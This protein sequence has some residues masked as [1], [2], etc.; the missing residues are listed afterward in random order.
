M[1]SIHSRLFAPL[2]DYD[3][4]PFTAGA[5]YVAGDFVEIGQ[6]RGVVVE[7]VANGA[8]GLAIVGTPACGMNV[9]KETSLAITAGD[10]LYYDATN[11]VVDKTNTNAFFGYAV[12]S[13]GSSDVLVR[14]RFQHGHNPLPAA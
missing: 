14:A 13:A 9:D 12:A 1:A 6:I 4:H 2:Q 11:D 10:I 7:D 3:V 5:D 8:E